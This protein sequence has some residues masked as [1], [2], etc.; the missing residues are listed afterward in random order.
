MC[1]YYHP[2]SGLLLKS[3]CLVMATRLPLSIVFRMQ[4]LF[5]SAYGFWITSHCFQDMR[6]WI[7]G[8]GSLSR[9]QWFWRAEKHDQSSDNFVILCEI[10]QLIHPTAS[11]E[12][13]VHVS[14][15]PLQVYKNPIMEGNHHP[16][17]EASASSRPIF[18]LNTK[19]QFKK[20]EYYCSNYSWPCYDYVLRLWN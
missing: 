16:L 14:G 8:I 15:Q 17:S 2:Q 5:W 20:N 18:R 3:I 1:L 12:N 4:N 10:I 7:V 19:S 9:S 13:P 6:C 11:R